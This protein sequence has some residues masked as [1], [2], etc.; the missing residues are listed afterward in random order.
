M[1]GRPA[2]AQESTI[3]LR[4]T[5]TVDVVRRSR[6]AIVYISTTGVQAVP[7]PV[8]ELVR[9]PANSLGSGFIIHPDGY[10]VTNN[11]VIARARAIKVDLADGRK[12][13]A[14]LISADATADLALLKID[15]DGPLPYLPLGDSSNLMIGEPVIAV[16]SPLG[17]SNSVSTGILSAQGRDLT[18]GQGNV[19][20]RDLLQTDAAINP[21]NSGGPLLNAYGQV[22]GIS[23]AIRRD[24]QNLGFA[25][26]VNKLRQLIP[27]LMNPAAVNKVEVP[28]RLEEDL[29]FT[30][31]AELRSQVVL[32]T[33][34]GRVPVQAIN[35][36]VLTNV[37]DAYAQLLAAKPGSTVRLAA[38]DGMVY[39]F[40]A[41]AVPTPDVVLVS[42]KKLGIEVEQMT[43]SLAGQ[44]GADSDSG[45]LVTAVARRSAAANAGLQAGDVIVGVKGRRGNMVGMFTLNTVADFGILLNMLQDKGTVTF[46]VVRGRNVGEFRVAFDASATDS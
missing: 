13:T 35:E 45:V 3:N 32:V 5:V 30:P 43:P 28:L 25:I 41:V 17:Y 19:L 46:Q 21:G 8:G 11:H 26:Q 10:V 18:D 7:N 34:D 23:T 14:R 39:R 15:A 44:V 36:K 38:A 16:G 33:K 4:E 6:D 37:V 42:R 20:L 31:P 2:A 29:M 40:D 24:A 12:F 27:D 9:I 1:P 22:I